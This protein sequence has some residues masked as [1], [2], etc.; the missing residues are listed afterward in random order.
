MRNACRM[1]IAGRF[2]WWRWTIPCGGALMV[3]KADGELRTECVDCGD[4]VSLGRAPASL[5]K[6]SFPDPYLP[7]W[8]NPP[9]VTS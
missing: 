5:P 6:P 2:L 7:D 9:D 8:R 4:V 3:I 1:P